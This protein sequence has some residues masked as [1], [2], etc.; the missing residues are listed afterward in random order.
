MVKELIIASV[1]AVG[2]SGCAESLANVGVQESGVYVSDSDFDELKVKKARQADIEMLF[3]KPSRTSSLNGSQIWYYDYQ[4]S[5][6]FG[7]TVNSGV[8]FEF[9]KKG[10][11]TKKTRTNGNPNYTNNNSNSIA[12]RAANK[13]ENKV[14]NA[15]DRA[16]NKVENKVDNMID[17]ALNK[18]F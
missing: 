12:D 8:A 4:K 10:V 17:R 1:L 2:F 14:D 7:D 5:S 9:N 3:G 18:I 15:V 6:K 11:L 16:T 13:A